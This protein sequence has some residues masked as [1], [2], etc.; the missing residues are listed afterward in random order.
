MLTVFGFSI[1]FSRNNNKNVKPTQKKNTK[2]IE[3][4][5][6]ATTTTTK[7]QLTVSTYA[8]F[9]FLVLI[10]SDFIF[11]VELKKKRRRIN[12]HVKILSVV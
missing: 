11:S 7:L 4:A 5:Q 8:F 1:I 6:N 3:E 12:K 10:S 2:G 9:V